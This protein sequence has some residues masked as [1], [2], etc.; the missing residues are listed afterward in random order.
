M[1]SPEWV[2]KSWQRGE[3]LPP[4]KFPLPPLSGLKFCLTGI[5]PLERREELSRLVTQLGGSYQGDLTEDCTHLL[6]NAAK[7]STDPKSKYYWAK[8]WGI[9]CTTSNWLELCAEQRC[10]VSEEGH[11]IMLPTTGTHLSQSQAQIVAAVKPDPMADA[12]AVEV[13][14][15]AGAVI[16]AL[17]SDSLSLPL[18]RCSSFPSVAEG[19]LKKIEAEVSRFGGRLE[20]TI[21]T[22]V[23]HL[24]V[25]DISRTDLDL[26][27]G[28]YRPYVVSLRWL[29][30]SMRQ[31][32]LLAPSPYLLSRTSS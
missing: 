1:V 28:P 11:E 10:Y 20:A 2:F 29:A 22:D 30:D 27:L 6:C 13:Q 31:M 12:K 5:E 26:F 4:E 23:T 14:F 24:L 19:T 3:L 15:M 9:K 32:Q 7:L 8:Q 17:G 25:T 18:S 16:C 21:T